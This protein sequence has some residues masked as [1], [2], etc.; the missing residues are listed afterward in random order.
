MIL[1]LAYGQIAT[2]NTPQ[3]AAALMPAGW[4]TPTD[5]DGPGLTIAINDYVANPG[6]G[7]EFA[8]EEGMTGSQGEG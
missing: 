1:S 2:P 8:S 7:S 5:A 4:V 6:A 3:D